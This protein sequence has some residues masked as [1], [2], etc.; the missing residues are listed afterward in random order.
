MSDFFA[1]LNNDFSLLATATVAMGVLCVAIHLVF[2]AIDIAQL[3]ILNAGDE[4]EGH[5]M[6]ERI[7]RDN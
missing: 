2:K 6:L 5:R 4:A 7:N 1:L 3:L